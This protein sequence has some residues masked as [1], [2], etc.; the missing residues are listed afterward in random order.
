M[1]VRPDILLAGSHFLCDDAVEQKV[2]KPYP[3]L[4]VLYLS[5][6][7]KSRGFGVEVFDGTFA[8]LAQ[9]EKTIDTI[10][11]RAVGISCNMNTKFGAL[12]MINKTRQ[13]GI[14][15]ILGGPEPVNYP[16]EYLESGADYIVIGE[17]E[18]TLEELLRFG[19]GFQPADLVAN[20][21]GIAFLD[22][23]GNVVQTGP[24][25]QIDNLS[26]LPWPD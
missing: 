12:R 9:F 8:T 7:L 17:G 22:E 23:A 18:K 5:S 15:T 21:A 2:M 19:T 13:R 25:T 14:V 3:P 4:G 6:Y 20:V 16:Q 10:Q 24:R 11:P 1:S 26:K